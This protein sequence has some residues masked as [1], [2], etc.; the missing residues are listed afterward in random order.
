[1]GNTSAAMQKNPWSGRLARGRFWWAALGVWIVGLPL[2][3]AA[4]QALPAWGSALPA[5]TM[6][7]LLAW[8]CVRR[9]HDRGL[10]S[11]WLITVFMPIL[12]VAWLVWQ[13]ALRSGTKGANAFGADPLDPSSD[14]QGH[15]S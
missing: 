14:G 13:L 1:M 9:L 8:L 2:L 6:L 7:V 4:T 5:G 11:A 15:R 3:D 12:G 10:R